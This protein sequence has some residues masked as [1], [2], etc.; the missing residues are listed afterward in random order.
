[1]WD[2]QHDILG[3]G[4]NVPVETGNQSDSL[5]ALV[6]GE[7]IGNYGLDCAERLD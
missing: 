6:G 7:I 2:D 4:A 1:V 3:L 5:H